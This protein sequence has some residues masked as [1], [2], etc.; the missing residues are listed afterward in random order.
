MCI[1]KQS[2]HLSGGYEEHHRSTVYCNRK[3]V[4]RNNRISKKPGNVSRSSD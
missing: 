4:T 1:Q 2:Q 3:Q